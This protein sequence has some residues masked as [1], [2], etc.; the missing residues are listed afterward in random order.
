MIGYAI[1]KRYLKSLDYSVWKQNDVNLRGDGQIFINRFY[2]NNKFIYDLTC[3]ETYKICNH[4]EYLKI[5]K[6]II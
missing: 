1:N 6:D 3:F 2:K 4:R 5:I